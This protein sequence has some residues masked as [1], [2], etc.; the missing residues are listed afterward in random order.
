[1]PTNLLHR[2]RS[3]AVS[4]RFVQHGVVL[5]A[6]AASLLSSK[7]LLPAAALIVAVW[8]L[9]WFVA[10]SG[11]RRLAV[12][13][14]PADLGIVLLMIMAGV[15]LL[16]SPLPDLT[17]PQVLR[18]IIGI[19]TYYAI[20]EAVALFLPS[21]TV[22]TSSTQVGL[23]LI[24]LALIGTALAGLA[25][26]SVD[27][28]A[29]KG[30]I[31]TQV[32]SRFVVLLSD[33]VHPNVMGGNLALFIP[34]SLGLVLF[35][36]KART[37]ARLIG[38]FTTAIMT[39]ILVLTQSRSAYVALAAACLC[40]ALLR[41]ATRF[42]RA[43]RLAGIALL[44]C[45]G[46]ALAGLVLQIPPF[47]T[48]AATSTQGVDATINGR[49]EI[50][51]RGIYMVQDFP[52][53]G[54]GMGLHAKLVE[55]MYPYFINP[56]PLV[57]AHNLFLQIA[58]DLGLPGLIAWLATLIITIACS[59]S[60]YRVGLRTNNPGQAGLAASLI[61]SQLALIVGGLTDAVTWGG[62]RTAPLVWVIW[63]VAVGC[64]MSSWMHMQAQSEPLPTQLDPSNRA[65]EAAA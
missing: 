6:C 5:L 18:L 37:A 25:P 60:L 35:L 51:S 26:I 39:L 36:P 46:F 38:I 52:F 30:L 55:V 13:A 9:R 32:Y 56:V 43:A 54:I 62:I 16:I 19:A 53:T 34:F 41:L 17:Q 14:T 58:V 45:I 29:N 65:T 8:L 50:W 4:F 47:D 15:S 1:M 20:A 48:V 11:S 21:N 63:G 10:R 7:L 12:M 44:V 33:S 31:P 61:A 64:W 2:I 49:I 3:R 59:I 23:I 57:H 27:W 42:P 28:Y 40:L 24:S 22:V